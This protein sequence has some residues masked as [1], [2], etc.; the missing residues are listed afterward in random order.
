M[1]LET[2]GDMWV[3]GAGILSNDT[4]SGFSRTVDCQQD[5]ADSARCVME[6]AKAALEEAAK[7]KIPPSVARACDA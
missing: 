6:F 4:H 1:Q 2:A 5:P 3:G 7:V